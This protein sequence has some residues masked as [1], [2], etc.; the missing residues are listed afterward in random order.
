MKSWW[1][2]TP[3][4]MFCALMISSGF[5]MVKVANAAS[6]S[7]LEAILASNLQGLIEFFGA[8]VQILQIIW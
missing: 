1:V 3:I 5:L 4:L 6:S 8:N 7:E 2:K